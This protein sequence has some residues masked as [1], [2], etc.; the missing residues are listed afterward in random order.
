MKEQ[1]KRLLRCVGGIDDPLILEAEARRFPR[2]RWGGV[3]ALAACAA[4]IIAVPLL[5][6]Q[7]GL[8][9][10]QEQT[11][12]PLLPEESLV[13][14]TAIDAP[15]CE[16]AG[17]NAK[18]DRPFALG[19][20][21]LGRTEPEEGVEPDE[22]GLWTG[23]GLTLRFDLFTGAVCKIAASE[24]CTLTLP[25]GLGIG[26][27]A[28]DIEAAYPTAMPLDGEYTLDN[29]D[30]QTLT[31]RVTDERVSE[32]LLQAHGD[33]LLEALTVP[34][35]T[36]IT[37]SDGGQT[38]ERVTVRDKAAKRICTTLTIS[39][40]E[41][42][43]ADVKPTAQ[44]W[45][46]F[47]NGAGLWMDGEY[48]YASV[49]SFTGETLNPMQTDGEGFAWDISAGVFVGL[50]DA[51]TR[52]LSDPNGTWPETAAEEPESP[53]L[54]ETEGFEDPTEVWTTMPITEPEEER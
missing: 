33:C 34:E 41:P 36:I 46:D 37:S 53:E 18:T 47:G 5:W 12:A 40:P 28:Q 30:G 50:Y 22:N 21:F 42:L 20:W 52:A 23:D 49:F 16:P 54:P 13:T 26:S 6:G 51:V 19:Q 44:I 45:I 1:E 11:S 4:L 39:E 7:G 8:E 32:I 29:G 3:L 43:T 38:W 35:L 25:N 48:D 14:E 15:E 27:P 10:Q 17:E 2:K 24:G 9:K 31:F